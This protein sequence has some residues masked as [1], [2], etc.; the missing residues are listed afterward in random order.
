M[1]ENGKKKGLAKLFM[2]PFAIIAVWFSTHVGPGFAGGAQQVR[3]W[4]AP[5]LCTNL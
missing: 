1:E 2:G 4:S 5:N 3:Y